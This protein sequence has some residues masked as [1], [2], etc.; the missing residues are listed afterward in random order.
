MNVAL[1]VAP[2]IL[3][4]FAFSGYCLYLLAQHRAQHLPKWT[5]AILILI[6]QPLGGIFY[7][8]IGRSDR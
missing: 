2:V 6:S 1:A 8:A 7:L 3:V 4:L 5:W